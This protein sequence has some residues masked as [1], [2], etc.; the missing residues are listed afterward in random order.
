M[1]SMC[2]LTSNTGVNQLHNSMSWLTFAHELG[3][4]FGGDHTFEEGQ[5]KTG[6]IMD[7]GDGKLNGEYQFNTQYRKS[8]MCRTIQNR[9]WSCAGNF[10]QG[11][12][13]QLTSW[14]ILAKPNMLSLVA[15]AI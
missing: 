2:H 13:D 10:E 15:L 11:D 9:K 4:N 5:G 7:Y 6:G 3:H 8:E 1:G 12:W 14:S